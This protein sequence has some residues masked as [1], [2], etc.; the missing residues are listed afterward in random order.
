MLRVYQAGSLPEA[1]L[2]AGQLEEEG[3]ETQIRNEAL[4]GA[5]GELPLSL[6]PEIWLLWDTDAE[7]AQVVLK[8]FELASQS[9]ISGSVSCPLCNEESPANFEICWK[10]RQPLPELGAVP[11]E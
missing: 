4:Q 2:L 3:I 8:A 1:Q 11:A 10:C 7:R 6:L 9:R 5:L